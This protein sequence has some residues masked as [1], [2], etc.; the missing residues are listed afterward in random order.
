MH[1]DRL[2]HLH[3]LPPAAQ[4]VWAYNPLH[5]A[6][7]QIR[8]TDS[9]VVPIERPLFWYEPPWI[10]L[11]PEIADALACAV[12]QHDV[13]VSALRSDLTSESEPPFFFQPRDGETDPASDTHRHLPRMTPYR[14]E[15]YGLSPSDFD[16]TRVI[17][18]R[19]S[20]SRDSSG[21]F[22]YTTDQMNRWE[23][24]SEDHPIAGGGYVAGGTFPNDIVS[25]KQARIKLDQLRR[26]SPR[27]AIFVSIGPFRLEDELGAALIAAPD[28]VILRIDQPEFEGIQI[29]AFVRKAREVMIQ[30]GHADLPLWIVPGDITPADVAKLIALGASAVAIDRWCDRLVDAIHQADPNPRY[31]RSIFHEL[32]DLAARMLW[33][34]IDT[35]LGWVSAITPDSTVPQRLGTFH[36]RWA[37]ACGVSLLSV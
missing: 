2:S 7:K 27:A 17:D 23:R 34:D 16:H 30:K 5:S 11:Q 6:A 12:A 26:L 13:I 9:L 15:R 35:V 3:L 19:L 21:R 4:G 1:S 22:A 8:R 29:A 36:P 25:L 10:T 14:I 33:N 18:V 24:P 20:P 37:Q 31:D 28:G 32:P